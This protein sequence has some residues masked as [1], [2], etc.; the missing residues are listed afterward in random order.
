MLLIGLLRSETVCINLELFK[1]TC[2][3][4][5]QDRAAIHDK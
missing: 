4:L 5:L 3:E 1:C 2:V